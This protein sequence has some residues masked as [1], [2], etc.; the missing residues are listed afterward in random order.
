MRETEAKDFMDLA[1]LLFVGTGGHVVAFNKRDGS[2]VWKTKLKSGFLSSTSGSFVTLLIEDD[3]VF[4]L[5]AGQLFCL[6]AANGVQLWSD[7]LKGLGYEIGS[8]ASVA[9]SSP[10]MAA[11]ANFRRRSSDAGVGGGATGA[12]ASH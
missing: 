7:G 6:D 2:Q 12:S 4:A 11:A 10:A 9:Q 1:N 8:L 3:R 5:A